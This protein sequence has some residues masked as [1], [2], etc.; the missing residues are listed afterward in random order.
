MRRS[1]FFLIEL[2]EVVQQVESDVELVPKIENPILEKRRNFRKNI[3]K[4]M[5]FD[6]LTPETKLAYQQEKERKKEYVKR[7]QKVKPFPYAKINI[8]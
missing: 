2:L 4:V 5:D 7:L 8:R 3:K 6:K 1:V